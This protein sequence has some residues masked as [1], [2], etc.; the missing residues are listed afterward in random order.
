MSESA[1]KVSDSVRGWLRSGKVAQIVSCDRFADSIIRHD[2]A[3]DFELL[4]HASRELAERRIS[5]QEYMN[6]LSEWLKERSQSI[7]DRFQQESKTRLD[8]DL[9]DAFSQ[10]VWKNMS[11]SQ[12]LWNGVAPASL[13]FAPL[14]AVIMLPIDFG[15]GTVL[16]F[17]SMKELFVAGLASLGVAMIQTDSLPK[18]A[19]T[20]A[21]IQQLGDLFAIS[22]DEFGIPRP[23]SGSTPTLSIGKS[24]ERIP[25][26]QVAFHAAGSMNDGLRIHTF[27]MD[28][29]ALSKLKSIVQDLESELP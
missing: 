16:V 10:S 21:A 12:R 5:T 13:V 6:F 2:K 26:S 3:G 22:C 19:E 8:Q 29:G 1:K 23:Q 20:K 15:G 25:D 11:W 7:L 28:L 17:A 24:L 27:R 18:I 4:F 9:L 14:A